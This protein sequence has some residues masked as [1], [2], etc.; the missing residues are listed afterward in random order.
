MLLSL[1]LVIPIALA[2]ILLA[3]Y[4]RVSGL[5]AML[6]AI[7]S[8]GLSTFYISAL[9][10]LVDLPYYEII[11]YFDRPIGT[12]GLIL[13]QYNT[14]F[15][16]AIIIVSLLVAIYSYPYMRHRFE[17]LG[18]GDKAGWGVYYSN[19][20]LFYVSMLGVSLS[21]NII[22]FYIF[23]EISLITSFILIFLYGYGE[24]IK[25]GIM[26]FVW[27]HAGALLFL[28]GSFIYGL[29][30]G[31]FDF[32]VLQNTGVTYII[33]P[34]VIEAIG[35]VPFL[36]ILIGLLIKLPALGFH[37]WL[38]Y[39]HAE[40]PTPISALLSPLLIGLG[41]LGIIRIVYTIFQSVLADFQMALI[42][43]ALLTIIYGG[44]LALFQSDFKRLLAYS[45]ISQ[46][47]YMLLGIATLTPAGLIGAIIQ[48]LSHAF[49]KATLFMTAG[50]II[51]GVHGL[52]DIRKMGGFASKMPWSATS[53][54]IGFLTLSGLPPSV[55]IVAKF[56]IIVGFSQL[57]FSALPF[58]TAL[59]LILAAFIGFG[60]TIAYSFIT[61]R[62]IFFGSIEGHNKE[63]I[64]EPS[65]AAYISTLIVSI[66]S[67]LMLISIG[68]II[69]AQ[70]VGVLLMDLYR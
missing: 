5:T 49:G 26:Y 24:R 58:S 3:L 59:L 13:D 69:N 53:A 33:N 7:V 15:V 60:L 43:W 27:T 18:A 19:Y 8:I 66:L 68:L 57:V 38:P 51:L 37:I 40:A 34:P 41:G 31:S 55:G 62:K 39:A 20:I 28:I 10:I 16:L 2:F 35:L 22:E 36:L 6:I 12:F 63:K 11:A 70:D 14:P 46:M 25:I 65:P 23:L 61:M 29:Q 45:S 30:Y 48:Y 1:S 32:I 52:R 9:Y 67:I 54:L 64:L 42:V 50:N 4:R 17:E 56:L 44:L 21:T 47:G